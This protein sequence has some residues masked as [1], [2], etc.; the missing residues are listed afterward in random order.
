M[1]QKILLLCFAL[2]SVCFAQLRNRNIYLFGQ[3]NIHPPVGAAY[4]AIWGYRASNGREYAILGCGNGVSFVDVTDSTNIREVKFYAQ[5]ETA[6]REMKTFSHYAYV[7]TDVSFGVGIQIYDLQYLPDSV[8]FVTNWTYTGF[9]MG[10]T[11]S[12]EGAYLYL[13]GGNN[14][15]GLANN[16]GVTVVDI[17]NP[18]SPVRR[19]QWG[20]QYIHDCRVKNDTIFACNI[21]DPSNGGTGSIYVIS[22]VNKDNLIQVGSWVNNP[23]PGPHN[24]DLTA[25]RNYCL[26]ADEINGN[27]RLMKIWNI[28]NLLAPVLVSTWQPTGITTTIVHNIERFGNFAIV[29]HYE[30]GVRVVNISNPN[31]PTEVAWYDTYP[32]SN[33]FGYNGCW[34]VYTFP[35][36]KIIASDRSTGLYV[37]KTTINIIGIENISGEI[38]A[39]YILKQNYPNPF[40]PATRI[41]F[42]IPKAEQVSLKVFDILG[43]HVATLADEFR[44][45]GN[46]SVSYDASRLPSGVYFYQLKSVPNGRQAGSFSQTKKMLLVK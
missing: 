46:Y 14:T 41:E 29:A 40:N 19:G 42:S 5:G 3:Q 8:H 25:D 23:N 28:T 33:N 7:V 22:A 20:I 13:N 4:S 6:W 12:Q 34:G 37:L 36:G 35:S 39:Q 21:Y 17:T 9:T 27:P 38:P 26:V 31:T 24:C 45:A 1:I 15:Q 11:I 2:S 10:H 18:I 43:K 44:N 32:G 30:A 16:G